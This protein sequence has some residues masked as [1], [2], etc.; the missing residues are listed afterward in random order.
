MKRA[1][2][3]VIG[4]IV[5]ALLLYDSVGAIRDGKYEVRVEI[6]PEVAE[7]VTRVSYVCAAYLSMAE[8]I[9]E[10]LDE[11]VGILDQVN[12]VPFSIRVGHSYYRSG[13]GRTWGHVQ[14]SSHLVV[15]LERENGLR[16]VHCVKI[17][18]WEES[19]QVVI[20]SE[21]LRRTIPYRVLD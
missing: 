7:G 3:A 10:S 8:N 14:I 11:Y 17:P 16:Q 1:A 13:L 15:V 21:S 5:L 20:T 2:I 9:V 6:A 12:A 19:N 4:I 18:D